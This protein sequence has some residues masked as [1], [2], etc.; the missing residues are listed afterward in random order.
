M[1]AEQ[2]AGKSSLVASIVNNI[3]KYGTS[4]YET[5]NQFLRYLNQKFGYSLHKA[6]Q[7][8][9]IY[10]TKNFRISLGKKGEYCTY[11]LDPGR[12]GVPDGTA[13]YQYFPF[14]STL[15]IDEADSYF[16][17]REWRKTSQ[18]FIDFLKYNRHN[19]LTI[20]MICQCVSN[21]ELKI[22][23]L[24]TSQFVVLSSSFEPRKFLFW[25]FGFW[26][27]FKFLYLHNQKNAQYE[28]LKTMGYKVSPPKIRE[29]KYRYKGDI[30]Q[31]YNHQAGI[32]LFLYGADA[33]DYEYTISASQDLHPKSVRAFV[34]R[35]KDI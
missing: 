4:R 28:V 7:P 13:H 26:S 23:E 18:N 35:L 30:R 3:F 15:V 11:D 22:R 10:S 17:C 14:G 24:A 29:C 5:T 33:N 6:P 1:S 21:L 27:K 25:T 2:G 12:I 19:G 32:A 34:E 31:R 9:Y 8:H 16:P 20:I